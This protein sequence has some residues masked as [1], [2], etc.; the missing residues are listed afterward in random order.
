MMEEFSLAPTVGWRG[1]FF[2]QVQL[3]G[4]LADL[5]FK[6]GNVCLVLGINASLRFI[7]VQAATIE[8]REP[9]LDEVH[10]PLVEGT[11]VEKIFNHFRIEHVKGDAP[12][13]A[14]QPNSS[15]SRAGKPT[16]CKPAMSLAR[17]DGQDVLNFARDHW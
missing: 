6:R 1:V 12:G 5:A 4:E 10:T 17:L 15:C 3:H 8:L 16:V 2:H 13:T 7:V 11:P 9:K 14:I